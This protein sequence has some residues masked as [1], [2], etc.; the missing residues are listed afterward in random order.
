[1][2]NILGPMAMVLM[3]EDQSIP[4]PHVFRKNFRE[5]GVAGT[6][7]IEAEGGEVVQEPQGEAY[8]LEGPQHEQGG[9]DMPPLPSG[10]VIY[11]DKVKGPDGKTMAER[12]ARRDKLIEQLSKNL[13]GSKADAI[14]RAT[15]E[16]AME[17]TVLE[18]MMDIATMTQE[19]MK[20]QQ[21]S[22]VKARTGMVV[23]ESGFGGDVPRKRKVQDG[24]SWD[25]E[26]DPYYFQRAFFDEDESQWDNVVGPKTAEAIATPRGQEL[27]DILGKMNKGESIYQQGPQFGEDGI[28]IPLAQGNILRDAFGRVTEP[29]IPQNP[30]NVQFP[31]GSQEYEFGPNQLANLVAPGQYSPAG[32][33]MREDPMPSEF[34]DY[35]VDMEMTPSMRGG[36]GMAEGMPNTAGDVAA[37]A[38]PLGKTLTTIF[39]RLG[40]RPQ[41]NFNQNYGQEALEL[42]AQGM[43]GMAAGRDQDIQRNNRMLN[44][45]RNYSSARSINT[46]RAMDLSALTQGGDTA[47]RISARFQQQ[48][49][50]ALAQRAGMV[51][52]RDRV[53]AAGAERAHVANVQDRDAFYTNIGQNIGDITTGV[54]SRERNR[55]RRQLGNEYQEMDVEGGLQSFLANLLI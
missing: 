12:K 42:N 7:G 29:D 50:Q 45:L 47:N 52:D 1:M 25:A 32:A 30:Y 48:M 5:G 54:Q 4:N 10:T 53:T 22:K 2:A 31:E 8:E 3:H 34:A 28:Q 19:F 6:L 15:M 16:R 33:V 18:D 21:G 36:E 23:P 9:I 11:S 43:R 55:L 35:G 13:K 38:G 26:F 17:A 20:A 51:N 37:I 46:S 14:H 40:D 44:A 24:L 39:N 27:M 41:Q 49:Q